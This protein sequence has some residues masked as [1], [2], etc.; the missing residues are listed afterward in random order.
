MANFKIPTAFREVADNFDVFLT[1]NWPASIRDFLANE[2]DSIATKNA[3]GR[4]LGY[5]NGFVVILIS[6]HDDIKRLFE[7]NKLLVK[8][9]S[10]VDATTSLLD[11]RVQ[12]LE[13][14]VFELRVETNSKVEAIEKFLADHFL[15]AFTAFKGSRGE[16]SSSRI[17]TAIPVELTEPKSPGEGLVFIKTT[18]KE[19]ILRDEEM[20]EVAS[21]AQTGIARRVKRRA[22]R[23]RNLV[24]SPFTGGPRKK[25][26]TQAENK[27]KPQAKQDSPSKVGDVEKLQLTEIPT[28]YTIKPRPAEID[29][30]LMSECLDTNHIDA[31]GIL[32]AEKNR[33]CPG[34]F[35]P[36]LFVS[37]CH[38][39]YAQHKV[40]TTQY[41]S[42]ITVESVWATKYLLL[43]I[44]QDFH[45]TL[46]VGNL[47]LK[48]WEFY[49]SLPKKTHRAVLPGVI[50]H[51][52]EETQKAFDEDI[53]GWLIRKIKEAPI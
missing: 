28:D 48:T 15:T 10:A 19:T 42:H 9:I 39:G 52:F 38:W 41:V 24:K 12:A 7:Q 11:R 4:S 6:L 49:D 43:P 16:E 34:L 27:P 3:K 32:L 21:S 1:Y 31:F 18:E 33:L 5:I 53:R 47:S 37:S 40:P 36:F 14:C 29:E 23:K 20:N 50:S 13:S 35:T 51:L 30:L 45:W 46:I 44:I 26:T 25:K 2:Y 22:D 17:V 8:K